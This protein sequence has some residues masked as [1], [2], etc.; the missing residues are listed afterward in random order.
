MRA[1]GLL[2]PRLESETAGGPR[3]TSLQAEGD[4]Q[5][6]P[7]GWA[8]WTFSDQ[9]RTYAGSWYAKPWVVIRMLSKYVSSMTASRARTFPPAAGEPSAAFPLRLWGAAPGGNVIEPSS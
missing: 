8:R 2:G 7:A 4:S 6:S 9:L 1:S 5:P 3:F